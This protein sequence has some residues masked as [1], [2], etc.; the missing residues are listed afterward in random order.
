M[1]GTSPLFGIVL[2]G[3]VLALIFQRPLDRYFSKKLLIK[4]KRVEA[5]VIDGCVTSVTN[6]ATINGLTYEF[7]DDKG[8]KR[9]K[10]IRT[11]SLIGTTLSIQGLNTGDKLTVVYK[12]HRSSVNYPETILKKLAGL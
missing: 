3:M 1:T 8:I 9:T 10:M 11:D 5:T 12:P 2:L 4:G 7:T 6:R